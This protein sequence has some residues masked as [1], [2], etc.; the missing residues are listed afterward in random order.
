MP[1][2]TAERFLG[3]Q[4]N[5]EHLEKVADFGGTARHAAVAFSIG[6]KGYVSTGFDGNY[7]KDMWAFDPAP[8]AWTKVASYGGTKRVGAISFVINSMAYVVPATTTLLPRKTGTYMTRQRICGPRKQTSP[9]TRRVLPAAT[10]LALPS[11]A[12][13]TSPLGDAQ[14]Q[15]GLAV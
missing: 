14:R 3:I 11:T 4:P 1:T 2:A 13:A 9:P 12:K 7:L 15:D 6:S 5:H 10:P 8:N